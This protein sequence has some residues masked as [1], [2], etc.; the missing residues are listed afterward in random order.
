MSI[1]E[2]AQR[3]CQL[4][5]TILTP[6]EFGFG[7]LGRVDPGGSFTVERAPVD[8]LNWKSTH[9]SVHVQGRVLMLKSLTR[10]QETVRREVRVLASHLSLQEAAKLSQP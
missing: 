10:E 7:L 4:H 6:V 2:S 9:V 1:R 8:A 5:A 3:L